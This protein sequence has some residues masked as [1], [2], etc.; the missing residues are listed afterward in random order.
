MSHPNGYRN[1]FYNKQPNSFVSDFL[2]CECKLTLDFTFKP[3]FE[4]QIYRSS[5]EA[6]PLPTRE[7]L[8]SHFEFFKGKMG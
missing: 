2:D 5:K 6:R 8:T 3:A 7:A 4:I 1:Q